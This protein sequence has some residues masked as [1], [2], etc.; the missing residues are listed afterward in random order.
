METTKKILR[1]KTPTNSIKSGMTDVEFK[2]LQ[3]RKDNIINNIN[4]M[5]NDYMFTLNNCREMELHNKK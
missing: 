2:Y 1:T 5:F 3:K 4:S